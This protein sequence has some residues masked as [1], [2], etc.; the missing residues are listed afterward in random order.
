MIFCT[1]P[2]N[3]FSDLFNLCSFSEVHLPQYKIPI[4]LGFNKGSM[5]SETISGE[6]TALV[7]HIS[8]LFL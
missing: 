2:F 6:A 8:N 3:R 5:Y 4:P 1:E 7:V